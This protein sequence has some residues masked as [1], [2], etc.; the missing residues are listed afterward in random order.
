MNRNQPTGAK[1]GL[2]CRQAILQ[3]LLDDPDCSDDR[4]LSDA[5][6]GK[7]EDVRWRRRGIYT[8]IRLSEEC[9]T[10]WE[11][12]P[13]SLKEEV[14]RKAIDQIVA[15]TWAVMKHPG[16][17]AKAVRHAG[18]AGFEQWSD[19]G[20]AP[21]AHTVW[22]SVAELNPETRTDWRIRLDR[23]MAQSVGHRR[24]RTWI[25]KLERQVAV[26]RG[27]SLRGGSNPPATPDDRPHE[28]RLEHGPHTHAA[29]SPQSSPVVP[30]PQPI[31]RRV[32]PL[33][34]PP[35][36]RLL[37]VM[38]DAYRPCGNFGICR[39]AKWHP[40]LGHVPRGILGATGEPEDVE[41]V[42]VFSEPGHP[43][44]GEG[45]A[46]LA[47]RDMLHSAMRHTYNCYRSQV[48]QFHNNVRWFLSEL[49]PSLTFDQQ[50]RHA[51]LTEGRLC[52]IEN[53]I[54][55]ITDPTCASHYLVR[56]LRLLPNAAVVAF[57]G[58]A[59]RYLSGI[60]AAH[61]S[62]YALAPPGANFGP[63]RPSWQAAIEKVRSRRG[64][65]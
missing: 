13:R 21:M 6:G 46:E 64:E 12:A 32:D 20:Y 63:A 17:S 59:Q 8:V 49:Y 2:A 57:G 58:K 60:G 48:D 41:I 16:D 40:E 38:L 19:D 18:L 33:V 30:P 45:H 34:P 35:N 4:A 52:S 53:E 23:Q 61:I 28:H 24:S 31:D 22:E 50:L 1:S 15:V 47:P 27:L 42:M 56:E 25:E 11:I 36:E 55:S 43:Q 26:L 7:K 14:S 54:G 37:A 3:I 62:A 51:W 29:A 9:A 10:A 5:G 39:E 65:Q 44:P